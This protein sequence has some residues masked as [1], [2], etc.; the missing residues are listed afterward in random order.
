MNDIDWISAF[1]STPLGEDTELG[2]IL[3]GVLGHEEN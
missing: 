1:F 3:K 2:H